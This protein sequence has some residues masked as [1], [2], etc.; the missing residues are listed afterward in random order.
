[1]SYLTI[2]VEIENG[3]VVVAEPEKLPNKG[4]GLLT[5]LEPANELPPAQLSPLEALEALQ[6]HLKLDEQ[7][8]AKWMDQV[9]DARR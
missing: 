6:T 9:R 8:A 4:K 2:E 5:V 3:R 7:K 1:M